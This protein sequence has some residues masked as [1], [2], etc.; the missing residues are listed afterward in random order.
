MLLDEKYCFTGLNVGIEKRQRIKWIIDTTIGY[1]RPLSVLGYLLGYSGPR[2]V[3]V[4][5]K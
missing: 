3:I 2:Q 4:H 1:D 5:Y